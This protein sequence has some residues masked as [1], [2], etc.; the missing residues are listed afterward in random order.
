MCVHEIRPVARGQIEMLHLR[1]KLTMLTG[2]H[3]EAFIQ[4]LHN[5]MF[6]LFSMT[7]DGLEI[8]DESIT[9]SES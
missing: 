3:A 8:F 7:P 4:Q 5:T 2:Q 9:V 1:L 6:C